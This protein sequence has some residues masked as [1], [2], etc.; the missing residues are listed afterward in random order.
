M[1]LQPSNPQSLGR[2]AGHEPGGIPSPAIRTETTMVIGGV[3][4]LLVLIL[5]VVLLL[6]LP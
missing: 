5:I 2:I 1:S 4:L 6:R 3:G